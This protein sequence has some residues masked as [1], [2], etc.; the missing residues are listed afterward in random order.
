MRN[1]HWYHLYTNPG[2]IR[3][4]Y[5]L[6]TTL[7]CLFLLD[8][9]PGLTAA[10][11][12]SPVIFL[13][14]VSELLRHSNLAFVYCINLYWYHLKWC[15]NQKHHL[16]EYQMISLNKVYSFLSEQWEKVKSMNCI[17]LV[18]LLISNLC[19][20]KVFCVHWISPHLKNGNNN[21][22]LLRVVGCR[23]SFQRQSGA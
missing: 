7:I 6:W 15:M 9:E 14:L 2:A 18:L 1:S 4:K 20:D 3:S 22:F 10:P 5:N 12:N 21:G 19:V 16:D 13:T 17:I 23:G 8:L 11:Y